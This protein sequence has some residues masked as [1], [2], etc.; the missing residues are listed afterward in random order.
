MKA[1][2]LAAGLGTRLR[3]HTDGQP[4]ALVEYRRVPLLEQVL[5]RLISFGVNEVIINLHHFPEQIIEFVKS[6]DHFGMRVEFSHEPALL[7]TGGGLKQ[8][9]WFFDDGQPF[10]L[11]NVDII[12]DIDLNKMM[13]AH[14]SGGCL[15]TL[16]VNQRET[17]RYF[18]FDEAGRLCGW[19]SLKDERTIVTRQ[20]H[21]QLNELGFCGIH[22]I[23][24]RIFDKLTEV[25]VFSI[26]DSYLR[27]AGAGENIQAFRV[28]E[29]HWLDVG[30]LDHLIDR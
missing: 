9:A 8:A 29:Y 27:L 12:S 2:I 1:M 26:V 22:V 25:G 10:L 24:P 7:D 19:K 6:K 20:P 13:D 23:S 17:K 4:K 18:L 30:K 14:R 15:A 3:P 28:D 11:H 5:T 16:A 21:G